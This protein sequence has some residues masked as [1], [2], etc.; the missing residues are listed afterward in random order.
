MKKNSPSNDPPVAKP[1]LL[2]VGEGPQ[3]IG[4]ENEPGGALAGLLHAVLFGAGDPVQ[5]DDLPFEIADICYWTRIQLQSGK[6]RKKTFLEVIKLEPD[7]ERARLAMVL[8]AAKHL[9]GVVILRDCERSDNKELGVTLRTAR[10][11]YAALEP[12]PHARPALIVAAASRCHETWL[13]ADRDAAHAVLGPD[14]IH[15]FSGDPEDR[16][17]CDDLKKHLETHAERLHQS[18]TEVRRRS[19][20]RG[21]PDELA[22]RCKCCYPPFAQDVEH[23]LGERFQ[24]REVADETPAK[25]KSRRSRK[26]R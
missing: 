11:A 15:P 1:C 20:F 17:H 23:E 10:D 12:P 19:S 6:P 22:K 9:A 2:F 4:R 8:A 3:D 13:L 25:H 16:P 24:L 26:K 14:G 5:T 18:L 7:A 21:R